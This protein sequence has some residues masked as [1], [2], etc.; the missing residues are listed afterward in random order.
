MD[1][2]ERMRRTE[3]VRRR[4][5]K[6]Y[7]TLWSWK[8]LIEENLLD[9]YARHYSWASWKQ[10]YK[11]IDRDLDRRKRL[12]GILRNH[13]PNDSCR[14]WDWYIAGRQMKIRMSDMDMRDWLDE[15]NISNKIEPRQNHKDQNG[16]LC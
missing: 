6:T 3:N 10:I 2:A 11:Y 12:K 4:R 16:K 8:P 1:K 7:D 9:W 14:E 5:L 13:L 15:L